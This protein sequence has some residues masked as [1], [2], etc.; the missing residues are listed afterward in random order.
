MARPRLTLAMS[1]WWS[2]VV[3]LTWHRKANRFWAVNCIKMRLTAG[4]IC[5]DSLGN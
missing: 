2:V 4:L 3:L 5:P 1:F